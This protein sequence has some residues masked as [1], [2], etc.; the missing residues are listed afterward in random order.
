MI[1]PSRQSL[2][3]F[4]SRFAGSAIVML[5]FAFWAVD[6]TDAWQGKFPK[7]GRSPATSTWRPTVQHG[8]VGA[9]SSRA[10][11]NRK[12]A[13]TRSGGKS[14]G[15]YSYG[16]GNRYRPNGIQGTGHRY[17]NSHFQGY[18][19]PLKPY[20]RT[21]SYNSQFRGSR[22]IG[23]SNFGRS[24][25]GFSGGG[26][27]GGGFSGGS[28]IPAYSTY[29]TLLNSG[30]V[31]FA[32]QPQP[33]YGSSVAAEVLREH[34][35][36]QAISQDQRRDELLGELDSKKREL[37][38]LR[39]Q[40][41]LERARNQQQAQRAPQ[42]VLKPTNDDAIGRLDEAA[43]VECK[44]IARDS[45]LKAE[46]AFR[47]GDYGQAARFAGVACSLDEGNGILA[48]FASQAYF[49][50]REYAD[51]AKKLDV[52]VGLLAPGELGWVVSNFRLFYGKNDY[53]QQ[54][55]ALSRHIADNPGDAD[56]WLLRGYQYAALDY[57]DA[58]DKD[59]QRA[60]SLGAKSS[61]VD[62]LTSRFV[63]GKK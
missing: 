22:G 32:A 3:C 57:P 20:S 8:P 2:L 29:G 28:I 19:V 36:Q 23:F 15:G 26:F 17:S 31:P 60:K 41:E 9:H 54:T 40:L 55:R 37:E 47:A 7:S 34:R 58:A 42:K 59:L 63:A 10:F 25:F 16:G 13:Q 46:R 12:P 56:A 44:E 51:A 33:A 30:A 50:N 35:L 43:V 45:Q 48:L 21:F 4:G 27:S 6:N 24:N 52:A 62:A 5:A 1:V 49:A 18:Y 14:R 53:V 11:S 39:L 38:I 61:L